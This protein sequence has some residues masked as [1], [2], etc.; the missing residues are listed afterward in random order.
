M[1]HLSPSLHFPEISHKHILA[2]STLCF[3]A[4]AI[5][6]LGLNHLQ[7]YSLLTHTDI[8]VLTSSPDLQQKSTS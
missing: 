2:I 3:T 4:A 6:L 8:I 1:T 5:V 7:F